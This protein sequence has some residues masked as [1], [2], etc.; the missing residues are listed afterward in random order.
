MI[1]IVN[2]FKDVSRSTST[3]VGIEINF[4]FGEWAQI[5]REMEI[6]SKSPITESGKWPLLA[7][8]TPFEEDKSD[9]D[10]YCKANIDLMIATRT[11][12]DYTNDQRLAISYKEILHPVY[13]HFISELI[14]DKRL[15]FGPKN[16]VPHRYVDNMRY[17]SRGVYGSDGKRPFA[18]L[19]DGIDILD[20][21][22]KVKKP[23][24]K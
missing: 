24:C 19:F 18:D 9:P 17:G 5:A 13:E 20:L 10:L 12:S 22:I 14:K 6:L 3:G 8:F 4:L 16:V 1:D 2:I 15:D 21:E 23:N 11:L 7:L